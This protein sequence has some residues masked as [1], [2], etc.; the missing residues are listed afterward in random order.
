MKITFLVGL[1]GSG[2]TYLGEL[3]AANDANVT[4]LDD[5]SVNGGLNELQKAIHVLGA[6][7]IVVSDAFLCRQRDR[8][9]AVAVLKKMAPAYA[10]EWVFFENAPE[11]CLRNAD[12]RNKGLGATRLVTRMIF[13]MSKEYA[14]PEGV[15]VR[16]VW[17]PK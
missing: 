10:L 16:E 5:I 14:I 7:N 2:K 1:P 11:K 9:Q 6:E 3:L 12:Y 8:E 17:Q 13:D 4:Y 15:S